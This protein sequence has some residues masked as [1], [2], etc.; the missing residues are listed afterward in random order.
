MPKLNANSRNNA[1]STIGILDLIDSKVDQHV[2]RLSNVT[3]NALNVDTNVTIGNDLTVDGNFTVLGDTTIISTDI[4]EIKDNIV[5]LNSTEVGAGVTLNLSGTE[6]NRGTF[7]NFQ[8]VYEESTDIY[9]IGEV[10][11]L[12][13]VATR[14][15]NPL[16]K[17][18]FVYNE[19]LSRIDSVTTVELPITFS[20]AQESSSSATGTVIITGGIGLTGNVYTDK[21]IYFKGNIGNYLSNIV[22]NNTDDL[23]I[24][25]GNDTIFSNIAGTSVTFNQDVFLKLGNESIINTGNNLIFTTSSGSFFI[26]T[27][28]NGELNLPEQTRLHW[29]SND[30][31]IV[32]NGTDLVLRSTGYFRVEA[33]MSISTTTSTMSPITGCLVLDGGLGISMSQDSV[34]S[35]NG[36]ALTIA[37]GAAIKKKLRVGGKITVGDTSDTA[38]QTSGQGV[39]F[40]S[41]SKTLTTENNNSTM[42]NTFEGGSLVSTQTI[43]EASTLFISGSPTISGGGNV[44]NSYSLVVD[45]GKTRI[46]GLLILD[47]NTTSSSPVLG[48]VL[49]SGGIS[50]SQ[51]QDSV[52]SDNGGALTIA[53]GAAIKKKLRVGGKITVGDTSDT[54]IQTSGQ[55]VT[56]RSLSKTLTTENNNSTMF[57]TFEGGSLVSTQTIPEASTLFISGSPTIS[58]GGVITDSYSL[59]VDQGV[60]AFKGK[61]VSLE[62]SLTSIAVSGGIR[63]SNSS[64]ITTLASNSSFTTL[65]GASV[66]KSLFVGNILRTHNGTGISQNGNIHNSFGGRFTF[67]LKGTETGSNLGSNLILNNYTDAGALIGSIF[68]VARSTGITTFE[69]TTSTTS[70]VSGS[71]LFLGGVGISGSVDAT[72]EDSGGSFTTAG[73]IA[74]KK[75]IFIGGDAAFNSSTTTLGTSNLNKTIISTANGSLDISGSSGILATVGATSNLT[76]TSG[77]LALAS[78]TGGV[79]ITSSTGTTITSDSNIL[80]S[81]SLGNITNSGIITNITSTGGNTNITS[82]AGIIGLSGIGGISLNTTDNTIGVNINTANT[83]GKINIGNVISETIVGGN[84]TIGGD[85]NVRGSTT[86]IDSTLITISDNAIVVNALPSGLSDGG[87]LMRRYQTSNN[88]GTGPV[89]NNTIK[90]SGAFQSGSTT[91]GTLKLSATSNAINNYYKGWWIKITSGDASGRVR[92]I[93]SSDATAKTVT[94]YTTADNNPYNDGL[95]LDISPVSGNTYELFDSPYAGLYF[96]ES[97][98]EIA[99][100]AVPFDIGTGQFGTPTTYLPIHAKSLIIEDSFSTNG[101]VTSYGNI[102]VIS[103]G[104]QNLRSTNSSAGIVFNVDTINNIITLGSPDKTIGSEGRLDFSHQDFVD[105][106]A[107]YSGIRSKIINNIPGDL[108]SSLIFSVQNGINGYSDILV[109]NKVTGSILTSKLDITDTTTSTSNSSGS[110]VLAGGLSISNTT[111]AI[112]SINGGTITTAGGLAVAK[113][114]FF[115]SEINSTSSKSI[116][117]NIISGTEGSINLSGDL[118]TTAKVLFANNSGAT[119]SFTTRSSG[120]RIILKPSTTPT[121]V[122]S[123]IGISG[124]TVWYSALDDSTGSHSFYLG[125]TIKAIINTSGLSLPGTGTGLN[126]AGSN[127]SSTATNETIFTPHNNTSS[128]GFLFSDSTGLNYKVRINGQGQIKTNLSSSFANLSEGNFFDISNSVLIDNDTAEFGITP[129]IFMT[130]I[131]QIQLNS[132]QGSVNT[133][134]SA[135][136]YIEGPPIVGVNETIDNISALY[137]DSVNSVNTGATSIAVASSIYIKNAPSGNNITKTRAILVESGITELKGELNVSLVKSVSGNTISGSQGA[138]NLSG[139]LATT[140]KVLFSNDTGAIPT[141]TSRSSGSRIILKPSTTVASVDSAIGVSGDTV[142]YSALDDSTGSHSFYLGTLNRMSIN[143]TGIILNSGTTSISS[144]ISPNTDDQGIILKGG[145]NVGAQLELYGTS[146]SATLS[147]DSC[148]FKTN[149]VTRLTISNTG[150]L[151]VSSTTDSTTSNTASSIKTL[152]GLSVAKTVSIGTILNLDFNQPYTIKGTGSGSLDTI[153][154]TTGIASSHRYFTNDGDLTDNNTISLF[155][156]GIQTDMT[157]SESLK[158]GFD[159]VDGFILRPENSGTGTLKSLTLGQSNQIKLLSDATVSMASIMASSSPTVGALK[160]SGGISISNTTDSVDQDN[161]GTITT[162]GGASIK[163]NLYIGGDLIVSGGVSGGIVD[164][165]LIISNSINTVTQAVSSNSIVTKNGIF[166]ELT[167]IFRMSPVVQGIETSFEFDLPDLTTNLT[168]VYSATVIVNGYTETGLNSIENTVGY[169]II[170]QTRVKVKFTSGSTT[171]NTIQVMV[172]YKI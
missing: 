27:I 36:G 11:D 97:A 5:L 19:T 140:A 89:V 138:L 34:N 109:L 95:D 166:R 163:K 132:T 44:T 102:T 134:E 94:I 127:I 118:A 78:N 40:R 73:G 169:A 69:N 81:S 91:P 92:R 86:T 98:Q 123:A 23:L 65:G 103:D 13:A 20:G 154:R 12:Q 25:T 146:G 60:S 104:L 124:D 84:I 75:R 52:N 9:K 45:Q 156:S 82:S 145:Y 47:N 99:I 100:A 93:K 15:D 90:E 125:T 152:G 170:G 168:T 105:A 130:K 101:S 114:S 77:T 22:S 141:F 164:T 50:I 126:L 116:L 63:V 135:T 48:S 6:V 88:I 55:G 59:V 38:I 150:E 115:G 117:G 28:L 155:S 61:I 87:V 3:F 43:P 108:K 53:G 149:A 14:E 119:P 37:G 57:N 85:L 158:L 76:V 18:L 51:T 106:T 54:A 26:N 139:D 111:D 143:P 172:K 107:L 16:D 29:G 42:F 157:N 17:G 153:S 30:N 80:I 64:D 128:K 83:G 70:P 122:D 120:S 133:T 121:A 4:V 39:T 31:D 2:L 56:F 74:V 49:V 165:T 35:D 72:S 68:N 8:A 142:W 41:L 46:S 79:T 137:I 162:A 7:V 21:G 160:L 113:K 110:I 147:G 167:S 24:N 144:I 136:N 161:G 32:F 96:S 1:I 33:N 66:S 129:K 148:I 151:I 112:S 131:S 10:G 159:T 58:G 67:G 71:V 171:I 62:N